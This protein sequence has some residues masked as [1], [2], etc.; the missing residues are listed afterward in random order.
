MS[1]EELFDGFPEIISSMMEGVHV[2]SHEWKYL[3][4]NPAAERHNRRPNVELLGRSYLEVWPGIEQ[5]EVFG[6]IAEAMRERQHRDYQS[7]FVF[8]DGDIGWFDLRI[9]P[10][11]QGITIMSIDITNQKILELQLAQTAKMEALGRFASGIVHDFN[12]VL[13]S[14]QSYSELIDTASKKGKPVDSYLN[15]MQELISTASQLVKQ[16]LQF[17]GRGSTNRELVDFNMLIESK[18]DGLKRLVGAQIDTQLNKGDGLA[19]VQID[20]LTVERVLMNLLLNARDA[21]ESQGEILIETSNV[22]AS[23]VQ[24]RRHLLSA[25]GRYVRLSVLDNG[26]GIESTR[27]P[28]IFDPFYT[29]KSQD[30]GTGLGLAIVYS[31][32]KQNSGFV[33]VESR[34]GEGTRFDLYFPAVPSDPPSPLKSR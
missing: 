24:E 19:P 27:I 16:I 8:P 14:I 4:L 30:E 28:H 7:Q 12:N 10:I 11:P 21:I 15:R 25:S 17:A 34:P 1:Q 3:Y 29:T 32:V 13:T 9:T 20:P 6:V 31:I 22:S 18:L 5:T 23:P 33:E 2:L 26:H